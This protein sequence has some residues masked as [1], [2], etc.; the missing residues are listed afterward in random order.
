MFTNYDYYFGNNN[1]VYAISTFAGKTVR[2]VATCSASDKYNQEYGMK[3]A[4]ARCN[5]KVAGKRLRRAESKFV[6]AK[7]NFEEAA[8]RF[9]RET[10]YLEDAKSEM[11]SAYKYHEGV[12]AEG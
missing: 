4:A 3:L 6:E 10:R 7:R 1:K 9:E 8:R 5:M 2:G 11:D 12:L